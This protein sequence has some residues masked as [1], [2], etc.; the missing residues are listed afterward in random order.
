MTRRARWSGRFSKHGGQNTAGELRGPLGR[1]PVV[2]RGLT[3]N[4]GALGPEAR[5]KG[6]KGAPGI[7]CVRAEH[8]GV[9]AVR[10][11]RPRLSVPISVPEAHL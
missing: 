8:G 2:K 1:S 4:R 6:C 9:L 10:E 5:P 3:V 7:E 11:P